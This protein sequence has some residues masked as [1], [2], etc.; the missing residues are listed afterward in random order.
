MARVSRN[1]ARRS[2]ARSIRGK[3]AANAS[4]SAC[5]AKALR[6]RRAVPNAE[7]RPEAHSGRVR[8]MSARGVADDEPDRDHAQRD[9]EQP[10]ND[11]SHFDAS[12]LPATQDMGRV[13]AE[14]RDQPPLEPLL[15]L[16][17]SG[18]E[19]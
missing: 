15:L 2:V 12:G 8:L 16:S 17:G 11:I 1:A 18:A 7:S 6:P 10:G 9:T 14:R 4:P 13:V 5:E 3:R 19:G